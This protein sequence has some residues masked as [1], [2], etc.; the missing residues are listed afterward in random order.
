MEREGWV[1][2]FARYYPEGKFKKSER[3]HEMR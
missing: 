3:D 2:D 1:S